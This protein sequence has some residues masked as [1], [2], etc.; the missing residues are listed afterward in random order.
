MFTH[1]YHIR[2]LYND[3]LFCDC[4]SLGMH[5]VELVTVVVAAHPVVQ[6]SRQPHSVMS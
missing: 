4:I 3:T 2:S 6:M 5:K 1:L